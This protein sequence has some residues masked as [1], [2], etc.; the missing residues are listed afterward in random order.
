MINLDLANGF[1]VRVA[2]AYRIMLVHFY[3]SSSGYPLGLAEGAMIMIMM[4]KYAYPA[5][6]GC[7]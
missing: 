2:I 4:P 6:L 7:G 1:P 3:S 5:T